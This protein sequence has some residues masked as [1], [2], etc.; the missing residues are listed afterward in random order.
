MLAKDIEPVL[1]EKDVPVVIGGDFNS[2]SHL[3]WTAG[4]AHLHAGYGPVAFPASRYMAQHGYTDTFRAAHPNEVIRP[5]GTFAGIYGQL[6]FSRIDF[7]YCKGNVRV[8]SSKI[9]Q[10]QPEIDDIW[11]SDH[12]AVL[13][14][15]KYMGK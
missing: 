2:C 5:E 6:D 10:T 7:I 1:R 9:V 3:D 4:A 11:P 15:F 14:T 12:S 8:L 13:T